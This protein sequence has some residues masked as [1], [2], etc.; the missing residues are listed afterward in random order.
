MTTDDGS[1]KEYNFPFSSLASDIKYFLK[2][3]QNQN[4]HFNWT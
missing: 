4:A 2:Q 3:L 1:L